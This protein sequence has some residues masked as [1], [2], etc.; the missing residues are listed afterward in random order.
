[1]HSVTAAAAAAG[2]LHEN[3][4][5]CLKTDNISIKIHITERCDSYLKQSAHRSAWACGLL[6]R[7]RPCRGLASVRREI[8]PAARTVQQ[9]NKEKK[10][11]LFQLAGLNSC[12]SLIAVL[13]VK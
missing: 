13:S 9:G 1:M 8:P 10:V 3:M 2:P 5:M 11:A 12:I 6:V 4:Q 7:P